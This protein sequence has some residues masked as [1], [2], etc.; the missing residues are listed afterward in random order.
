MSLLEQDTARVSLMGSRV[1]M[2]LFAP[3][4]VIVNDGPVPQGFTEPMDL[5]GIIRRIH[6]VVEICYPFRTHLG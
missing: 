1:H 6:Q 5:R 2:D 4:R 3:T